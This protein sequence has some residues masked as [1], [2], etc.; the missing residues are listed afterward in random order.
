VEDVAPTPA[1]GQAVGSKFHQGCRRQG[2]EVDRYPENTSVF[3][4]FGKNLGEYGV[5]REKTL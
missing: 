2:C 5:A 3:R 1:A 4:I